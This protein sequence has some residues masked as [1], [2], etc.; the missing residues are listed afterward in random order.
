MSARKSDV[1]LG[2]LAAGCGLLMLLGLE[3]YLAARENAPL[4]AARQAIVKDLGLTDLCLFTDT[5]YTRNP[6]VADYV[7]PFQDHP[8]ALEHFPSGSLLGPPLRRQH[9]VD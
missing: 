2:G 1:C 4:I 3:A 9:G 5:Q 7:T 6:A 8:F